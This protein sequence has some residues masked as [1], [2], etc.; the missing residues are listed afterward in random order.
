MLFEYFDFK[1][2]GILICK[3]VDVFLDEN[4]CILEIQVEGGVKYGIKEVGFWIVDYIKKVQNFIVFLW[5]I[6][7]ECYFIFDFLFLLDKK[8]YI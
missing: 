6:R 2:E 3:V 5:R 8:K 1:E 7:S 4:V